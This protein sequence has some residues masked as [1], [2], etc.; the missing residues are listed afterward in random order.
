[1]KIDIH[2]H[3]TR[4]SHCS[5]ASPEAMIESAMKNGIEGLVFTEHNVMWRN[6]E[7]K[8]LQ[9]K[10]PTVKLF[11]GI[12]YT[13][14]WD[15]GQDREDILIYGVDEKVIVDQILKLTDFYDIYNAVNKMDGTC[16]IAHPFRY[17]DKVPNSILEGYIDGI[18]A[19]SS[20]ISEDMRRRAKILSS[21]NNK[22][23]TAATD[24][25]SVDKIGMYACDFF[26]DIK[27][28]KH[29]AQ[30]LKAGRYKLYIK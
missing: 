2:V 21:K 4:Y 10:Y 1:M 9:Q 30:Q 28:E 24:G 17:H 12:E 14:K 19:Y 29:L 20:N 13:V 11:S 16:I 3:T 22:V 5:V 15:N 26:E 25:H 23:I 7:I 6:D 27:D 18:E 8:E